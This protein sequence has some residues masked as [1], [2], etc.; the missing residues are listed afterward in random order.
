MLRV[1]I[2]ALFLLV[3]RSACAAASG[4]WDGAWFLDQ[5]ASRRTHSLQL[6]LVA[7]N[8][9]RFFNGVEDRTFVADGKSHRT[10]SSAIERRASAP[11]PHTLLLSEGIHGRQYESDTLLL[12]ADGQM[13]TCNAQRLRWNGES[14]K[15]SLTY[16]RTSPGNTFQ[17][18]WQEVEPQASQS[19]PSSQPATATPPQPAWVIWTGPDGVMTWFIP[20]TG[21]TLRGRADGAPRRIEGPYYDGL[22]SLG[23]R[24]RRTSST[25]WP[26]L[27]ASQWNTPSKRYLQTMK[28]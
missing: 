8:T 3:A 17:G 9:W 26:T 22:H 19:Q 27:M 25:L 12:S 28:C 13:L 11:N 18:S 21:E 2:L 24:K 4:P 5:A 6:S 20:S 1:W 7:K 16:T 15:R 10:K 14:R 23:S